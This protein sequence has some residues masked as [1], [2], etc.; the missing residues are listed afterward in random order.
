MT[1]SAPR[2]E[3]L[4]EID[5][6][7]EEAKRRLISGVETPFWVM[8]ERQVS[9]RGRR[10]RAW[11]SEGGNLF[12]SGTYRFS[13]AAAE[14]AQLSFVTALA[15]REALA[16]W[17]LDGAVSLKWPNDLLINEAKTGGILLESGEDD[18]GRWLVIGV[19]LNIA[20]APANTPY[21]AAS[22]A[23]YLAPGLNLPHPEDVAR[24]LIAAFESWLGVWRREG[25]PAIRRAWLEHAAGVG[26]GIVVKGGPEDLYGVFEDLDSGGALCLRRPDGALMR[27]AAGDVFFPG[28]RGAA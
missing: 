13:Q 1:Q 17:I 24:S 4:S 11:V 19:G 25:F 27:V 15:A 21:P 3:R 12:L 28:R 8:A 18:S 14:L 23:D 16:G 7:N 22:L 2:L 26:E 10:G 9:G 5:S 6:T 20:H